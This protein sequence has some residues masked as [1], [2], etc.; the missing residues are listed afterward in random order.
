MP[1]DLSHSKSAARSALRAMA[2]CR[3]HRPVFFVPGWT[4]QGCLCWLEPDVESGLDR[5][6]GWEYTIDDWVR[7]VVEPTDAG[8]VRFLRLVHDDRQ[9][10]IERFV[11]GA[12]KG[13]IKRVCWDGDSS[14]SFENFFQFAELLKAKIRA[15]GS[16]AYDLVGHSM[17]GLDCIA[18][19]TLD[20][21]VDPEP[22][23]QRWI[24][25][26]PLE[27][28]HRLITVATPFRGSPGGWLT[29]HTKLDELAMRQWSPAIRRQAEAMSPDSPFIRIMTAPARQQRLVARLSGGVHTFGSRNDIAVPDANR[30]IDGATNHPAAAFQLARHSQRMGI[31][32]DPRL[33]LSLFQILTSG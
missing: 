9:C 28:S 21:T 14:A 30:L 10:L 19:L 26:P 18:A 23:V 11:S 22:E 24:T 33:A 20:A 3:L 16:T 1:T 27:G 32:Q 5:R 29:K 6:P 2:P 12:R 15:T 4:D 25:S 13:K 8:N 7:R 31:P 17:G